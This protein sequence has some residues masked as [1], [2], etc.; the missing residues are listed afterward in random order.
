MLSALKWWLRSRSFR[1]MRDRE[2]AARARRAG[3]YLWQGRQIHYRPGTSDTDLIYKVLL[4]PGRKAE[5]WVPEWLQPRVILDIG[6]NIGVASIYFAHRFPDARI[7]AFEPIPENVA[8]LRRNTAGCANVQVCP[9]ALGATDGTVSINGSDDPHN[10]GGFS[11]FQAGSD[12]GRKI[13]V[14]QRR[15]DT[16]LRDLK[17]D[18]IDL[19]KIDTEGSEYNIL[20]AF[21]PDLLRR[22]KW[23]IGELHGEKDFELL[24]FLSPW[25]DIAARKSMGKRLFMFTAANKSLLEQQAASAK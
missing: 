22:T 8:L 14:E 23:V 1:F 25:F 6:G 9:I 5:Y 10:F 15:P 16:A 20:T 17:L 12:T 21:D 3:V 13:S 18:Q 2:V 7:Y 19:I 4:K 11:F 24:A